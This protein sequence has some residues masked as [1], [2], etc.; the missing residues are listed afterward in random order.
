LGFTRLAR[1]LGAAYVTAMPDIMANVVRDNTQHHRFELDADGHV[2][3]SE[4]ARAGGVITFLHT[5]VPKPLEGRSIGSAL[6]KGALDLARAQGAKVKA[7]C[8]FVKAWLDKHA[9][10]ADLRA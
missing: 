5:E 9:D 8:P 7:R 2:A 6:V 1:R 3:Y 4:Y 10:Y